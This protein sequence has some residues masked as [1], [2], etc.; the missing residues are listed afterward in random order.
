[1]TKSGVPVTTGSRYVMKFAGILF[2]NSGA[3]LGSKNCVE[4]RKGLYGGVG[5]SL[6]RVYVMRD[7]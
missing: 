2:V 1:V 4:N 3:F 5:C 6:P 7:G